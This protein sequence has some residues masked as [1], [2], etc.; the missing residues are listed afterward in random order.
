M[1]NNLR[2]VFISPFFAPLANAE[3]FCNG[4]L[5]NDLLQD[6]V[7]LKVITVDY[8]ENIKFS[9]DQSSIWQP[10]EAVTISIPP[11]ANTRKLFSF[12]LGIHYQAI[13]WSRWINGVVKE[14]A[15]LHH[16]CP[17]DIIYSRGLPNVAHIAGYWLAK[18]LKIKWIANFNDP[19]DLEATH[20]LPQDRHLRKKGI[21]TLLSDRWLRIV[22]R[23][24]DLLTFPCERLRDYHLRLV[25]FPANCCVIPHIGLFG[26]YSF[27]T[28]NFCLLHAGSLGSG[29]STRRGAYQKLFIGL[30]RFLDHF[31]EA[32]S[33]TK[34]LLVGKEDPF[35]I[36][37][38][39]K[40]N[41]GSFISF[42]D[43]VSYQESIDYIASA[44]VCILVE[45]MMPEG[46][47]LP[48]KLADY[49]VSRKPV[50]A[51]SPEVGTIADLSHLKGITRVN[52]DDEKGIGN[53]IS[54]F[55][56]AFKNHKITSL[57]PCK[58]LVNKF[59]SENVTKNFHFALS[60]I[61]SKRKMGLN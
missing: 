49:I 25:D 39:K 31:P 33:C 10:L 57:S 45:G 1:K 42:T 3:A 60:N 28:K 5:V 22:M 13:N 16:A 46:I 23:Q 4:K 47:Y 34:V 61:L 41:L 43:W 21:S 27:S 37:L 30:R 29:E 44:S 50:L 8:S 9:Y 58:E 36:R 54:F 12:F 35:T 2:I 15:C 18:K 11:H 19:W 32:Q 17:F 56:N 52:V 53:A 20:L 38:A 48:S 26:K 6:G 40:L 24:A 7:D 51:L 14:V 59:E 55:Y